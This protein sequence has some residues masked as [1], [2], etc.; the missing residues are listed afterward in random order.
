MRKDLQ[1]HLKVECKKRPY[2]CEYCNTRGT[3]GA[4]TMVHYCTCPE[5]PVQCPNKCSAKEI[6]C[7]K[8]DHHRKTC[9]LEAIGCPFAE[10]GC[11]ARGLLR[12]DEAEHMEKNVVNHQLLMLKSIRERDRRDKKEWGRRVAAIAKHL[13]SCLSLALKNKDCPFNQFAP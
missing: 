6:R 5:F 10:E 3:Y 2:Q 8:L 11:E 1:H 9:P 7:R 13:N 12:K 4:I